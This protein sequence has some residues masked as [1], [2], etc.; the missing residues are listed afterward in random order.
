MYTLYS[1]FVHVVCT[2]YLHKSLGVFVEE[3]K[4]NILKLSLET[5]VWMKLMKRM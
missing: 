2:R 1:T 4:E 5:R 3:R